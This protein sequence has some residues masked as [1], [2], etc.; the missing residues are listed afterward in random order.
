M[1][2]YYQAILDRLA[3]RTE[4]LC[5]VPPSRLDWAGPARG[6]LVQAM[7]EVIEKQSAPPAAIAQLIN[8][9]S[10]LDLADV[11]PQVRGLTKKPIGAQEPVRGAITNFLAFRALNAS[12]RNE[13][14][15]P[16]PTIQSKAKIRKAKSNGVQ[17]SGTAKKQGPTHGKATRA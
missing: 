5:G 6:R 14:P 10:G 1:A 4:E 13:N 9:A 17:L 16:P 3:G 15:L 2:G 12:P 8:I 11:E 7:G